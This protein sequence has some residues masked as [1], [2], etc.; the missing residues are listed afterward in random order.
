[1]GKRKTNVRSIIEG[2]GI[3]IVILP[4]KLEKLLQTMSAAGS[5]CKEK[6][7]ILSIL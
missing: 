2:V 6:T 4:R 3:T 5:Q 7:E 1:M